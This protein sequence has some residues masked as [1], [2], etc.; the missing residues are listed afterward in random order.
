MLLSS[1]GSSG[2]RG[3]GLT[4]DTALLERACQRI[5][6][7]SAPAFI[8]D[9]SL[10]F[11]AVNDAYA[12]LWGLPVQ[13]FIG[14]RSDDIAGV[15]EAGLLD[16]RQ[17]RALVFGTD[18]T[19]EERD[20]QGQLL[21]RIQI[22][23]FLSQDDQAYVFV[24]YEPSSELAAEP[25]QVPGETAGGLGIHALGPALDLLETG[26]GIFDETDR[27]VY[28]NDR[29]Q[30]HFNSYS[31][32]LTLG[33]SLEELVILAFT[34]GESNLPE[35][36]LT[37]ELALERAQE[38]VRHLKSGSTHAVEPM[39]DGRWVRGVS[40][41]LENGWLVLLRQ[42]MTDHKIQEIRLG[43]EVEDAQILRSA[44]SDIPVGVYLRDSQ[45]RLVFS[46]AAF[47]NFVRRD[48]AAADK[49]GQPSGEGG[50]ADRFLQEN[51]DVL[52]HGVR[53]ERSDDFVLEDGRSVAAITRI[54][55]ISSPAGE[56][57]IVGSISDVT[58]V[59]D[60]QHEAERLHAEVKEI[61]QSLPV[62]VA[63]L[64][65]DLR[66]E[67]A[68][69]TLNE[70]WRLEGEDYRDWSGALYRDFLAFNLARGLYGDIELDELV[71]QRLKILYAP[72]PMVDFELTN[73]NGRKVLVDRVPLAD[74]KILFTCVDITNIRRREREAQE[75]RAALD[76]HAA[77]MQT[78]TSAMSQG[79]LI[80]QGEEIAFCNDAVPSLLDLPPEN[81]HAGKSWRVLLERMIERNDILEPEASL[82]RLRALADAPLAN[83][84]GK[85]SLSF[86]S[87]RF[88]DLEIK[89]S[90]DEQYLVVCTDVTEVRQRELE[91]HALLRRAEAA[92]RAKSEFLANMSHEIRTPMNG[93]LGMA[94]L[95]SKS[96]LD[97]RQKAF[98]EI[99]LKSGRALMTIIND[100]LDFSKIDAS[101]MTL[102]R[103]VFD[104][105]D[106]VED[107]ATLLF[108]SALEKDL[109]LIVR[110]SGG[111]LPVLGDAGRFRQIVTNLIGNAIK[112]TEIGHVL[113][114][115]DA[116]DQPD[117]RVAVTL[118]VHDTGI[119]IAED[120][121]ERIFE[122]FSQGDG[123]STRRHEGTGL[124]LAIT[125]G[126]VDIFGGTIS[127]ESQPGKGSVFKVTIAFEKASGRQ[128][129]VAVPVTLRN[130]KVL[131]IDDNTVCREV[132]SQQLSLWG[133]DGV[134]AQNGE[135]G[136]AV[137]RAAV[138]LGIQVDALILDSQMPG[139]N[140]AA[141]AAAIRRDAALRDL[142]IILLSSLDGAGVESDLGALKVQAQLMKPTRAQSLRTTLIDVIRAGRLSRS[143]G[144]AA[145]PPPVSAGPKTRP[146]EAQPFT[147][148]SLD[149]LVAEDN[150]VNRIVFTQILQSLNIQFRI[151]ENGAE[152]LAAWQSG[153][154]DLI[155]MD[156]SMPVM[157][158]Y[159]A[160]R[161]IRELEAG[162]GQRVP[163]VGVTAHALESDRDLC[164]ASGMDDYLSKP[165]SPELLSAKIREWQPLQFAGGVFQG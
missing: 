118:S 21:Y 51:R 149:V 93:V 103:V 31:V 5:G 138:Q 139:M 17:R 160:T 108:S 117:N 135:E 22:E 68:N 58:L 90:G 123:S 47:D 70:F 88:V 115:V 157:N 63:I 54:G 14:C 6:E 34:T 80:I 140:G 64:S 124:G 66:I 145:S 86:N 107:V 102:R 120:Q 27:L 18:E 100:V 8:K 129:E 162:T 137:L 78:A 125:A 3:E 155:L 16:D 74:G 30:T 43:R 114:E 49:E 122:K 143:E 164:L 53:I 9:S 153:K 109:E 142:P 165:I 99:I 40:H 131:V 69:T 132:L 73:L 95:L 59:R 37:A 65:R 44:F 29:L 60:A 101:Q 42:D 116:E 110:T 106:A 147:G 55:R 45:G 89:R 113:V 111:S 57:Y 163:I 46:N 12:R 2:L 159:Q 134:A 71:E 133:F 121:L 75:A 36:M 23:R 1:H 83:R 144:S 92:D 156:V 25:V 32:H 104:A 56:P 7:L 20:A 11:I 96:A 24:L 82:L 13:C 61:L 33:Q 76:Q 10:R 50:G 28:F 79:L 38:R 112:F 119:G 15:R 39:P 84:S 85:L 72:G 4:S 105:I 48:N 94:E 62:G 67:Y 97:T 52:H 126:L 98:T 128:A 148:S 19:L 35:D 130:A 77:L 41:R 150:E 141:V 161:R 136:L 154:P 91:L 26:I 127:V 87:G 152:A 81:F 151:V 158:G 146:A